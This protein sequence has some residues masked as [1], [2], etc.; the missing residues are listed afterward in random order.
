MNYLCAFI[1]VVRCLLIESVPVMQLFRP[2]IKIND[3][4]KSRSNHRVI[5]TG[6]APAP[7]KHR[8]PPCG[9]VPFPDFSCEEVTTCINV[10]ADDNERDDSLHKKVNNLLITIVFNRSSGDPV[11]AFDVR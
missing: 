6:P 9:P 4:V 5:I 7:V 8:K 11:S 1:V 3:V 2:V 10:P